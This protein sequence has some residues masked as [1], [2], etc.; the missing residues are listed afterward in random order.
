[1]NNEVSIQ[2]E[3][4][5]TMRLKKHSFSDQNTQCKFTMNKYCVLWNIEYRLSRSNV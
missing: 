4:G 5:L 2:L 3:S 1:M